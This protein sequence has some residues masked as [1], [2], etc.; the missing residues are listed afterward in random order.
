MKKV[1][2][3]GEENYNYLYKTDKEIQNMI[4]DIRSKATPNTILTIKEAID[5]A[6]KTYHKEMIACNKDTK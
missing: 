3:N 6:I 5:L 1:N 2:K 4:S